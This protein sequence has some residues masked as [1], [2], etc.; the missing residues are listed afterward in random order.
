MTKVDQTPETAMTGESNPQPA[1]KKA[2]LA[3]SQIAISDAFNVRRLFIDRDHVRSL[4]AAIR[5]KAPV[6]PIL[7]WKDGRRTDDKLV[8]LDGRHRIEAYARVAPG[9]PMQALIFEGDLRDAVKTANVAHSKVKLSLTQSERMDMAWRMV[10]LDGANYTRGEVRA[11]CA[12]GLRSV[13][14][15][16]TRWKEMTEQG[17]EPSGRWSVDQRERPSDRT[18]NGPQARPEDYSESVK[19]D[20][21]AIANIT[22]PYG[23]TDCERLATVLRAAIGPYQLRLCWA[24]WF[25]PNHHPEIVDAFSDEPVL[26]TPALFDEAPSAPDIDGDSD[27]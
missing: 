16:N 12:V 5:S 9:M 8:L 10:R 13:T 6:P 21:R 24:E 15:M 7:V 1:R 19:Q 11:S 14:N 22:R 17:V 3:P 20:A 27:F 23:R 25:G 26:V 2:R 18:Q 4:E